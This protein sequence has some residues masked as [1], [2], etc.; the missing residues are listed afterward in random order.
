M[1]RAPSRLQTAKMFELYAP[2]AARRL[3]VARCKSWIQ[4]SRPC[5]TTALVPSGESVTY[6]YSPCSALVR[7]T[8]P[9]RPTQASDI[10]V[11]L[12]GAYTAV[13]LRDT[14][15]HERVSFSTSK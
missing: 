8:A 5:R 14:A 3:R 7:S 2:A 4:R 9:S 15:S 10:L 6:R 1:M 12:A 11:G 13:P